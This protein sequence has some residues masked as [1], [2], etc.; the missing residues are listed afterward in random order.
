MSNN[1]QIVFI[2]KI[3][4]LNIKKCIRS[5]SP[6]LF[7]ISQSF[8]D[9]L[10]LYVFYVLFWVVDFLARKHIFLCILT[11]FV[12]FLLMYLLLLYKSFE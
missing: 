12:R 7:W 1:A 8:V 3:T 2:A 5:S 11:D 4:S 9:T 6:R 10:F